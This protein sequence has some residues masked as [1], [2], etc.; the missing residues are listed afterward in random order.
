MDSN[1]DMVESPIGNIKGIYSDMSWS[2]E[3]LKKFFHNH[4]IVPIWY[5]TT[6]PYNGTDEEI[7]NYTDPLHLV[8][9]FIYS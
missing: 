4:N 6:F 2:Y 3:I 1:G 5:D 8:Y 7:A 9:S